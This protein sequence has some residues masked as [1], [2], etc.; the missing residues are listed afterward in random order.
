M[1]S[2]LALALIL[3]V[4][5]AQAQADERLKGIACRSVHLTYPAPEGIA[6]YNEV[7]VEKSADGTYFMAA[8]WSKGYFGIQELADGKK[9]VLFSV[10]EPTSGD[11]PK[12][13]DESKRVKMLYKDA[14]VRVHR[15]G[16]EGTGGQS[17]FDYDW[18]T[19]QTY[20]F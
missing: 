6:F 11:N 19:S 14:A 12:N 17:F 18:R 15:F 2:A 4:A 8:G 10:W 1:R 16:G 20:R 3:I 13:V 9:L 7:T 5:G